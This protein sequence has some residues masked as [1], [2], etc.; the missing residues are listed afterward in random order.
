MRCRRDGLEL[1][2]PWPVSNSRFNNHCSTLAQNWKSL[3]AI[4]KTLLRKSMLKIIT[5][6]VIQAGCDSV[7][8][9]ER[10]R[11]RPEAIPITPLRTTVE[12]LRSSAVLR[13][14]GA[15]VIRDDACV[16]ILGTHTC[17][18]QR[19]QNSQSSPGAELRLCKKK[20]TRFF[21][22]LL[23]FC[24]CTTMITD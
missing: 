18:K 10:C 21:I 12:L 3:M 4:L 9:F 13:E 5:Q 16:V 8:P 23:Y 11:L 24:L 2:G 19:W 6:C 22:W 1:V 15:P 17:D 7:T 20:M 14:S